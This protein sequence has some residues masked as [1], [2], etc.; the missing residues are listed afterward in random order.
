MICHLCKPLFSCATRA[1]V[2]IAVK[3]L[4]IYKSLELC[5]W[6]MSFY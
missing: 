5:G 6:T 2:D 3:V 1:L 4:G